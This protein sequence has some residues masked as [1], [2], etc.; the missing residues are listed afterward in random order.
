VYL[1]PILLG[2]IYKRRRERGHKP[3]SVGGLGSMTILSSETRTLDLRV[4]YNS[5]SNLLLVAELVGFR[6][7]NCA[8]VCYWWQEPS[9]E[10]DQ[11]RVKTIK[12]LKICQFV[13]GEL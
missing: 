10:L 4:R 3:S 1:L 2:W 6:V 12:G 11:L 13:R 9:T 8:T 5:Y 7:D